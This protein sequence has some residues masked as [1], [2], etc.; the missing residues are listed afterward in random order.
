MKSLF[1]QRPG[2][3]GTGNTSYPGCTARGSTEKQYDERLKLTRAKRPNILQY[4]IFINLLGKR[5]TG[6]WETQKGN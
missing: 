1:C 2:M 4:H 5:K 3:K 6:I